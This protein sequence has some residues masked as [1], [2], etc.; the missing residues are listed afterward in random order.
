MIP[1]TFNKTIF[2]TRKVGDIVN[3]EIDVFT[4]YL[5]KLFNKK[6]DKKEI[7]IDLLKKN[8]FI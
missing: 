6:D 2:H 1:E 7:T 3:I 4:K 8:G 5:E